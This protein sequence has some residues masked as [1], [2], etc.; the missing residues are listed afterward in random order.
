MTQLLLNLDYPR[1][2]AM[3]RG[4]FVVSPSNSDAVNF[5]TAWRQWPARR[6]CL[7]GP[8]GS[9]KTHL[10]HVWMEE[11]GA[12]F[13]K[14]DALSIGNIPNLTDT[15]KMV[16][17][18]VDRW[19]LR[20]Q[21]TGGQNEAELALLHL[22]NILN[23]AEGWLMLTGRSAPKYWPAQLPDLASR[24]S[25][26]T[27]VLLAMP[28]DNLLGAVLKKQ[29]SDRHM[30]I[31]DRLVSFALLRM[32]RSFPGI[33][34]LVAAVERMTLEQ[35]KPVTLNILREALMADVPPNNAQK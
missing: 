31:E 35:R 29:F 24:L 28:D 10:A 9:G 13:T 15:Q 22:M 17:E 30:H 26:V 19:L 16:V 27:P 25:A 4:D 23:E 7:V 2:R 33:K 3:G 32:E 14:A 6:I 21:G 12:A 18:D 20:K 8:E 34:R 11:A 5:V 1:R